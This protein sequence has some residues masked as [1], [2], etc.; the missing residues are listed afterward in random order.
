MDFVLFRIRFGCIGTEFCN[1]DPEAWLWARGFLGLLEPPPAAAAAG[2]ADAALAA[3]LARAGLAAAAADALVA[4]SRTHTFSNLL[5]H[6]D[7]A[8]M[9]RLPD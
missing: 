6:L 5:G 4:Q 3:K 1:Y 2:A 7:N 8:K 9:T